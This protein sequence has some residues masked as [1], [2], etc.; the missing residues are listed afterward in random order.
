MLNSKLLNVGSGD[1]TGIAAFTAIDHAAKAIVVSV[2]GSVL[3]MDLKNWI[4]NFRF[5]WVICEFGD[6]CKAHGGFVDAYE[7]LRDRNVYKDVLLAKT[8]YPEYNIVVTGHSLG[9]A[10]ASLLGAYLRDSK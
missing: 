4:T 6:N 8:Q 2:R 10:V 9:G 3:T 5:Q 7:E 1:N